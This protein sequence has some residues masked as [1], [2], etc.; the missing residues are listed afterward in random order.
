MGKVKLLSWIYDSP[1]IN[2]ITPKTSHFIDDVQKLVTSLLC[3]NN[4]ILN[5]LSKC[6]PKEIINIITAIPISVTNIEDKLS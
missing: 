1:L 4:G 5:L 2:K 3:Q 6:L